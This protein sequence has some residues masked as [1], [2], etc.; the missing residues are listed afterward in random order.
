M[1][2]DSVASIDNFMVPEIL[3]IHNE[4]FESQSPDILLKYSKKMKTLFYIIKSQDKPVGY[5]AYYLKPVLF[6]RHF[7]KKS[8]IYSI[9]IDKSFRNKGFGEKLLR[10]SIKE[11]RLNEISSVLLYVNVKNFPA[12][13][14]YKKIG[15]RVIK[16]IDDLCGNCEICYEMELKLAFLLASMFLQMFFPAN[17]LDTNVIGLA[18][19]I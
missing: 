5:C 7:N 12:I 9:A 11:M 2:K 10:E 14:L 17:F 13:N 16:Q 19:L 1:D 4:G 6:L 15:F 18:G 3:R 8:V